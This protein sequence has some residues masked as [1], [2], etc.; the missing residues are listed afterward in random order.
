MEGSQRICVSLAPGRE[1]ARNIGALFAQVKLDDRIL[2]VFDELSLGL[3]SN[4]RR[5][6]DD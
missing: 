5:T 3:V 4:I 1:K 2:R 6:A